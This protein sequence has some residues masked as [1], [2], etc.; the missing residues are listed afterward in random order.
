MIK[1]VE[2]QKATLLFCTCSFARK[3]TIEARSQTQSTGNSD[4]IE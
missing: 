3:K 4:P 2:Q 1:S